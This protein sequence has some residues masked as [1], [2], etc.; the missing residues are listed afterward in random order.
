MV[1]A[2][3]AMTMMTMMKVTRRTKA[4]KRRACLVV[5]TVPNCTIYVYMNLGV[6][7]PIRFRLDF[8]AG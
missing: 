2:I 1:A 5:C 7:L 6:I 8:V 3:A 4:L